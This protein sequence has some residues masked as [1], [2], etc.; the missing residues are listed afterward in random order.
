MTIFNEQTGSADEEKE[1]Q[2]LKDGV[3]KAKTRLQEGREMPIADEVDEKAKKK[4]K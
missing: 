4:K 3:A 1:M 2:Q